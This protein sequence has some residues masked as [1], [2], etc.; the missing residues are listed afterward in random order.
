MLNTG[1]LYKTEDETQEEGKTF[2]K[3]SVLDSQTNTR[4]SGDS[5][6]A[7]RRSS[8][9]M[10]AEIDDRPSLLLTGVQIR[11][12]LLSAALCCRIPI[13]FNWHGLLLPATAL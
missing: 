5:H 12:P 4:L 13:T 7:S 9:R 8:S 3:N 10:L 11:S 2:L 1:E 6:Y